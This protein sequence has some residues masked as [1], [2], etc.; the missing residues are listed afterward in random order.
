MGLSA[1]GAKALATALS[2]LSDLVHLR[3][4][5][6]R[7]GDGG[8]RLLLPALARLPAVR[9]VELFGND[10]TAVGL[11]ALRSGVPPHVWAACRCAW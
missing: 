9:T 2:C 6:N 3:L 10:C 7:L 1:A 4:P 5:C 8:L 11:A